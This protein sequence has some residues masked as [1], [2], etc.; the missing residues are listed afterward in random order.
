MNLITPGMIRAGLNPTPDSYSL[1]LTN[2]LFA[3]YPGS[4]L[5]MYR[6]RV[7]STLVAEQGLAEL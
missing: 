3:I 2:W 7:P 6:G 4:F 1:I 5:N